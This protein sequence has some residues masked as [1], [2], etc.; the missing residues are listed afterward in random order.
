[1]LKKIEKSI[2]LTKPIIGV[3][4]RKIDNYFKIN[5]S[6]KNAIEK[7]GG[8]PFLILPNENIDEVLELCDGIIMPGGT[9]IYDYDKYICEYCIKNDKPVL[10][11]CLGMQIMA[12]INNDYLVKN[13]FN[14]HGTYHKINTK[15]G[16]IINKVIGDTI[17]NSRH[18]E[19]VTNVDEYIVTATSEDGYIEAIEYPNKRFNIGVQ[20][21][22]E[23][24][25][26]DIKEYNLIKMFIDSCKLDKIS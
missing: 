23:D 16:S 8:I 18:N 10:G 19:H 11:I 15:K 24:M 9:D 12:C 13:E 21:H 14:H 4:G 25:L 2:F 3:V 6:V 1:M 7:C 26:D 20:W 17:V 5:E 22:P